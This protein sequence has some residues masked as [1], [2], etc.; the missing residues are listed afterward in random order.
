LSW[1][2]PQSPPAPVNGAMAQVCA[3]ACLPAVGVSASGAAQVT[4]PGP[5][6]YTARVW[7]LD[8]AGRGGPHNAAATTV[9]VPPPPPP[10]PAGTGRRISAVLHGRQLRVAGTVAGS[11]R[12][13]VS[14]RSKVR[15]HTVGSG[16]KVVAVRRHRIGV[17]FAIARRARTGSATIRVV[18]RRER[19]V[20]GQ[21]RARRR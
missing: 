2:N 8:A 12:V 1:S 19:K 20:V 6:V 7:L 11:G 9:T 17:T 3:M 16:S 18:V 21:A 14:W 10:P 5:G 13:R 4:A 15:G